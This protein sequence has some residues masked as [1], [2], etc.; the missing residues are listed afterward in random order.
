MRGRGL[1]RPGGGALPWPWISHRP[2][3][4]GVHLFCLKGSREAP[5]AV[6]KLQVQRL[7]C[8]TKR[9]GKLVFSP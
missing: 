5:L 7:K 3:G 8:L 4:L 6:Q 9:I 2:T 1:E